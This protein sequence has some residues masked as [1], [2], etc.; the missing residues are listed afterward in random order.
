MR[1]GSVAVPSSSM[2]CL[3][4]QFIDTDLFFSPVKSKTKFE[5]TCSSNNKG[6]PYSGI[7]HGYLIHESFLRLTQCFL[8]CLRCSSIIEMAVFLRYKMAED[9]EEIQGHSDKREIVRERQE[10]VTNHGMCTSQWE[11]HATAIH[12]SLYNYLQNWCNYIN[13][14]CQS[15]TQ[16]FILYTI[17]IVYCQGDM[18][19]PLL[20]H[21]QA[22]WGN[23]SK[24]NLYF[25]HLE[26]QMLTDSVIWM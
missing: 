24:S 2:L 19:R 1:L 20:R 10:T 26:S 23:R 13:K 12:C 5:I 18:F 14:K 4:S 8:V 6:K 21:L 22:L 17:K 3:N 11:P 7:F 15:I 25:S 16:H 9:C